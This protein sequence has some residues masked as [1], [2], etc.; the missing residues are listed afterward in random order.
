VKLALGQID[1]TVADFE[2]T[3]RKIGEFVQRAKAQKADLIAFP[4]MTTTGYPPR[5]LVEVPGFVEKNLKALEEIARLASGIQ[6]AVGYV[7]RNSTPGGKPLFNAAAL[8]RDGKVAARYFK[9]LLPTYDVFDEGRYFEPGRETGLWGEL[10]ISICEDCWNDKLFW[11]KRLYPRDP[12]EEQVGK[13]AKFLLN[14]SASPFTLGKPQLRRDM[15]QA[16]AIKHGV[17][18]F[19]VN[20]VG[21]NDELVFDGRSLSVNSRGEI[22]AEAKAYEEELLVVDTNDLNPLAKVPEIR[23]IE[24]VYRTLVLGVRDYVRKCGFQKVVLGLSGGIDS[25]LTAVLAVAALGPENV[26]GVAMPSPYS[27]EGSLTDARALAKNLGIRIEEHPIAGVYNAYRGL[28]G[29]KPEDTPDLA[30]EN[31]QA[32]IRGNILMALSN[33]SRYLVLSTG[34]KSEIA[35]GYCTLYGDMSGGLAVIADIPKTMV[36]EVARYAQSLRSV[37]PEVVFTKPP[38]AELKPNQMDMDSLPPYDILDGILK[39]AIEDNK[40]EEEIVALGFDGATVAKVVRWIKVNEYKRRQAA[41]G[42]KVTSKAFGIGRRYPIARK[43]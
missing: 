39:A 15:L 14:I 30:D 40:S 36:Y 13:G 3:I 26:I 33:R 35:V 1:T 5:D 37:I 43:I 16:L 22:V 19:Y 7:E 4:E 18:I 24:A 32:R 20:L 6:I 11:E 8:C 38:S 10:G 17:P 27:S 21:G 25:S 31:V 12:I 2:G 29:R 9:N 42:I 41:P 28:F 34:N 23:D